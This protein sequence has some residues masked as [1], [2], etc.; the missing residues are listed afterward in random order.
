MTCSDVSVRTARPQS[1]II[2]G[3][4]KQTHQTCMTSSCT[5]EAVTWMSVFASCFQQGKPHFAFW[6][7][8]Q[9]TFCYSPST[10]F[11]SLRTYAAWAGLTSDVL[12]CQ[13][14]RDI[15][16]SRCKGRLVR[17]RRRSM[18]CIRKRRRTTRRRAL[19]PLVCCSYPHFSRC[20]LP[21]GTDA[22]NHDSDKRNIVTIPALP[23]RARQ[24]KGWASVSFSL[25]LLYFI[26][27]CP[28]NFCLLY[29]YLVSLCYVWKGMGLCLI[30][31]PS[32]GGSLRRVGPLR[33]SLLHYYMICY[34]SWIF[35]LFIIL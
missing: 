21:Q 10:L 14:P 17:S 23:W 12:L 26:F 18:K 25:F 19:H 13:L 28:C 34:V 8:S 30:F 15:V 31:C 29:I 4:N 9:R 16:R 7:K 35:I 20:P 5:F 2:R 1:E 6:K 22:G 27:V 3:P 33:L 24:K 11:C 32:I